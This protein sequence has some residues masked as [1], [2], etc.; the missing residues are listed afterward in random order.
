VYCRV[1]GSVTTIFNAREF[2]TCFHKQKRG[3]SRRD[4]GHCVITFHTK[5][6]RFVPIVT[7]SSF[8][9][10]TPYQG[11]EGDGL[12]RAMQATLQ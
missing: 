2:T 1:S 10:P 3:R 6:A 9:S 7:H 12:T 11:V 5:A 8:I 4:G